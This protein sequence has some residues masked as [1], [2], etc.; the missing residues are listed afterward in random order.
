MNLTK[1]QLMQFLADVMKE[2]TVIYHEDIT[3]DGTQ[4]TR[5]EMDD[6]NSICISQVTD[7]G[8]QEVYLHITQLADILAAA[9]KNST[10]E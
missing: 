3:T 4:F 5:V 9:V 2:D 7:E 1:K 10:N 8:K 6:D